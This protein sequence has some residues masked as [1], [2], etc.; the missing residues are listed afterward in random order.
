MENKKET[1]RAAIVAAIEANGLTWEEAYDLLVELKGS[2]Y[3]SAFKGS[4]SSA[5]LEQRESNSDLTAEERSIKM[6]TKPG[7]IN[8]L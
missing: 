7:A 8:Y 2:T 1:A 5:L 3:K 6:D 4:F